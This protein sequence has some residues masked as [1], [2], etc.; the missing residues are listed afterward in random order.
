MAKKHNNDIFEQQARLKLKTRKMRKLKKYTKKRVVFPIVFIAFL[1]GC[2]IYGAIHA[3]YYQSTDDAFIEG[4]MISVAPKVAGHVEKM[5]FDDNDYVKKGDLLIEIDDID[6]KNKVIELESTIKEAKANKYT[7]KENTE[8]SRAVFLEADKNTIAAK[9]KLDFA[10][11]DYERYSKSIKTGV[12]TKQEYEMS[13]TRYNVAMQEFKQAQDKKKAMNAEVKSSAS[14]GLSAGY[15][16]EKLQAQ[17]EMAKLNLSYTKIYAPSSG[18]ISNRKVEEGNYV[19]IGQS[20]FTIVPDDVWITANFKETQ[21]TNMKKGQSVSIK[22]DAY[23]NKKF[24]GVVDSIQRASGAK[25]SLLP[26]ENAVGSYVKV[27]Q[28]IP[29]KIKFTE[30]VSNYVLAPG[31]SVIPKVKIK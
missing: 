19:Q 9:E 7:A 24:T 25:A 14:K 1:F 26:P 15:N 22:I 8:K 28:R 29:V 27:V 4:R 16:I 18:N 11:K 17:L 2:I 30:D 31:M 5:H 23:P 6:Y 3:K 21:L 13:K 10:K 20:L 12:C